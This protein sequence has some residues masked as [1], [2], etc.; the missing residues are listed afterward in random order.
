M[1]LPNSSGV[2]ILAVSFQEC[3][4]FLHLNVH[5]KP[6]QEGHTSKL[7]LRSPNAI[8]NILLT[9]VFSVR[10]VSY[11]SSF[12]TVRTEK[13]RF[14]MRYVNYLNVSQHIKQNRYNVHT[15]TLTS[16]TIL[17]RFIKIIPT[18]QIYCSF[19]FF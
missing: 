14:S 1:P 10:S 3:R 6:T 11:G 4:V 2:A 18:A 9:W 5:R 17:A 13:T 8:M 12:L 7:G 19:E 16:L 15:G